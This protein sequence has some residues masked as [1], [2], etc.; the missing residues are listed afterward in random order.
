MTDTSPAA[1]ARSPLSR[2]VR[3]R[4][5]LL[6]T[7]SVAL[8]SAL[9]VGVGIVALV[10]RDLDAGISRS[11]FELP[12][13][14]D[15]DE[16]S[17]EQ[18]IL[19]MG[20]D[21][22]VDQN[23]KALPDEVYHALHA[24]DASVGGYN[25]NVLILLHIPEDRSQAVGISIPRDDFVEIVGAPLGVTHAK[26]KEAYGLT[27]QARLNEQVNQGRTSDAEG[28]QEARAEARQAQIETVSRFLGDVRIDHFVEVTMAGFYYVAEAVAPISVCVNEATQDDH[29][30]ANL[31]A[32]V[33]ELGP[34]EALAFVRQRRDTAGGPSLTDLDRSRRQQAFIAALAEKLRQQSTLM[35]P[36]TVMTLMEVTKNHVAMDSG[37]E[38]LSF[39][40]T[41]HDVS[42][43]GVSFVTLPIV[44]FDTVQGASVNVVD[45]DEVRSVVAAVLDG[46]Y[47][48]PDE[49]AD[50]AG[51]TADQ[52]GAEIADEP[53]IETDDE[54]EPRVAVYETWDEPMRAGSLP[55]VN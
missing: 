31:T 39:L 7:I 41:A 14:D 27:L 34:E 2:G 44:G 28:Y 32:G 5:R 55:C 49:G 40:R 37:F 48:A 9:A 53:G 17:G 50:A 42:R 54:D 8:A 18:N 3:R 10:Y 11:E 29:S 43:S 1:R 4:R 33:Q 24:G 46:T 23:G 51:A 19:I 52:S 36:H 15:L 38:V 26:I 20:L 12:F 6:T 45:L 47:F 16:D 35:N 13:I 25:A 30:G 22:R 21:S